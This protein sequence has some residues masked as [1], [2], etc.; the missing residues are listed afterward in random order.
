MNKK[1]YLII[2]TLVLLVVNLYAEKHTISGY[3]SDKVSGETL[4]ASAVFDTRSKKGTIAN[5][6]GFYSLSLPKGE[7]VLEFSYVGYQKIEK[8]FI[9][10]KDTV[11]NIELALSTTLKDVVVVGNR[12]D[13]GVKG[14]QMSAIEVPISQIKKVPSLLGEN[15]LIKALQLLPGVQSGSE[16][17]AG[18]YVR[19]GSPDQNLL[20]LDGVPV[21]NV[22]HMLG[23]FSVFNSDAIKNVTMY[24]GSFPAR[25]GGRLSSVVDIR[26]KDGDKKKYHGNVSIG[27]LSAKMQIEGP[28]LSENTTFNISARRTYFDI[29]A[30]PF[31]KLVQ[32]SKGLKENS[33]GYYF[34]DLN[35]KFTHKFSDKDRLY[36]STYMGDDAI[37]FKVKN[38]ETKDSNMNNKTWMKTDWKWGNLISAL[39]WNHIVNP[40]LFMN[41][42][43]AHTRYRSKLGIGISQEKQS[44]TN[45]KEEKEKVEYGLDYNS[46]I[47]DWTGKIDFDYEPTPSHKIKFG[48]G[49][50]YH[51]FQPDVYHQKQ[52]VKTSDFLQNR[53][54]TINGGAIFSHETISY[55]EDNISIGKLL[56]LNLGLHFSTFSVQNK[57]YFS[58]QPRLSS[59]FLITDDLSLKVGYAYMKQYVH[60]LS[61]SNISFPTDL[62]VPVTK[63]IKPMIAHQVALGAFYHWDNIGEFSLEGYY[64]TMNNLLEYKDGANFMGTSTNWENKVCMGSGVSYGIEFLYQRNFGKTTGWLG[65]TWAKANRTFDKEGNVLNQGLPFPARYDRRHDVSLTLSHPIS[66]KVELSATWVY[67]TGN[68]ATLGLQKYKIGDVPTDISYG[69]RKDKLKLK[70]VTH[71]SHRNNYRLN[72]YHRLDI[73]VNFYKF[74]KNGMKRTINIS[75]Y[76]TYNHYNPFFVY[77]YS[78]E[79]QDRITGEIVEKTVLRQAT[80]FPIIPSIS[81]SLS[82]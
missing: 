66:K 46:A 6:Y 27:L 51:T 37:Y 62:W 48:T 36:L 45:G 47:Y 58:L 33:F 4:I 35:A 19:G 61:N 52:N 74:Y 30:Y 80:M 41:I 11:L 25:F 9:L 56:K 55:I 64:K 34:Y 12:S 76:N 10:S 22:N 18:M 29:L 49:Y 63:N 42:T 7:V 14:S 77:P 71:I 54:T 20:L 57:N 75:V 78:E 81:Y 44:I 24:K 38:K 40:R 16:G 59:R 28:I 1:I 69:I 32:K 65:Y 50:T 5:D 68:T 17:S 8:R 43:G 15:D 70:N 53:D 26:M 67:S 31:V 73:G 21:Y 82:F 39:R 13:I 23:F 72:S 2:L 79:E 60:L 3:I